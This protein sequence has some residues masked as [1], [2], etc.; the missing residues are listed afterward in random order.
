M[1]SKR[2]LYPSPKQ[3]PARLTIRFPKTALLPSLGRAVSRHSGRAHYA[4]STLR[5]RSTPP[6]A[7][8]N[9][10][11]LCNQRTPLLP[12]ATPPRLI[13]PPG[14]RHAKHGLSS[15]R[16]LAAR[17]LSPR[18]GR[19]SRRGRGF[20]QSC[21]HISVYKNI[22]HPPL[23][24]TAIQ[25]PR[26][27]AKLLLSQLHCARVCLRLL[28]FCRSLYPIQRAVISTGA[29]H[30]LIVSSAVEKSASCI[31]RLPANTGAVPDANTAG[32]IKQIRAAHSA[33]LHTPHQRPHI[34]DASAPDAG[35]SPHRET[36]AQNYPACAYTHPHFQP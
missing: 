28:C 23:H 33:S 18:T 12:K 25:P 14:H 36:P 5:C 13:S 11:R 15:P 3:R 10:S 20:Q 31:N 32:K 27:T 8:S 22:F 21:F 4:H 29:A 19:Q 26:I 35:S 30:G 6:S 34:G 7:P 17:Y 9:S 24:P 1:R 16:S 2:L